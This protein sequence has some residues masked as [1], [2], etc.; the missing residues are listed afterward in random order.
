MPWYCRCL[1]HSKLEVYRIVFFMKMDQEMSQLRR[2]Q[3]S[4]QKGH[5]KLRQDPARWWLH[6]LEQY[7]STLKLP[8]IEHGPDYDSQRTLKRYLKRVIAEQKLRSMLSLQRPTSSH[9]LKRS[10][11]PA[12]KILK[13]GLSACIKIII[14]ATI[15][16]FYS[17][18]VS[19]LELLEMTAR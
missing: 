8:T 5:P 16:Y 1:D 15:I 14:V 2:F 19:L 18:G 11:F 4:R 3:T 9:S 10:F 12:L 13:Y 17:K 6:S 7:R